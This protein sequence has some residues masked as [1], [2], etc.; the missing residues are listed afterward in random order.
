MSFRLKRIRVGVVRGGASPEYDVSLATGAAILAVLREDLQDRYEAFDVLVD[1]QGVW[2]MGGL[3][4]TP[5]RVVLNLDIVINA[6]HGLAGEDGSLSRMLQSLGVPHT[7]ASPFASA[8]S[9]NKHASK[10][11]LK[12]V[13]SRMPHHEMVRKEGFGHESIS[14]TFRSVPM[15]AIVKP[16]RGSSSLGIAIVATPPELMK[17]IENVFAYDDAAIVEEYIPGIEITCGVMRDFRGEPLY[18]LMPVEIERGKFLSYENKHMQTTP[19]R[20]PARIATK[21]KEEIVAL[22]KKAHEALHLGPYS[23]SDFVVHPKRGVMFLEINSL[24]PMHAGSFFHDGLHAVGITPSQFWD[25]II[26]ASYS[27]HK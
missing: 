6:L 20:A 17:A 25:H 7:G 24:P 2:H 1:R 26:Y 13:V 18:A 12:K 10:K 9:Y 16:A 5:E 11:F 27:L 8:L 23:R 3:P 14:Q 19:R 21:I 4:R 15:P 22:A